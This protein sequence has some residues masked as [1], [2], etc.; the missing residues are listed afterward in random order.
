MSWSNINKQS[1]ISPEIFQFGN[2]GVYQ[3]FTE[4]GPYLTGFN[5]KE[6]LDS[7]DKTYYEVNSLGFRSPEFKH[8]D[9][10]ALGCSQTFGQ[11]VDNSL[12]WPK[13][14]SD[15]L[16]VSY[17][18]L[19]V[20]SAGIQT[21]L[22]CLMKYVRDYG[23]PKAVAALLPGFNRINLALRL[24]QNTITSLASHSA[25]FTYQTI[26]LDVREEHKKNVPVYS[27]R[28]HNLEEI[29][30][31]E[32]ALH[33][34]MF[35]LTTLIEYCRVAEI[36]LVFSTWNESMAA[37]LAEKINNPSTEVDLSDCVF[38]AIKDEHLETCHEDEKIKYPDAWE[39]GIDPGSHMGVHSHIHFAEA[40][41]EKLKDIR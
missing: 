22:S 28:P 32:V 17:V 31:F 10:V 23:K 27:K 33:Q 30:S 4:L 36:K 8:V 18:N 1:N 39:V 20:P 41:A 16:G 21:M 29:L 14:L 2:E 38:A 19:G 13:L 25:G 3:F 9:L 11:G 34:S 5:E 26:N 40:F 12:I 6:Y 24:D 37:L 15:L 35:A 7:G